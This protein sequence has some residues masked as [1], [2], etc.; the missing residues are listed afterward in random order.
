MT[1]AY[2]QFLL[3]Q[4]ATG[5]Y[6]HAIAA[7][8]PCFWLY[9]HIGAGIDA[10]ADDHPYAAWLREYSDPAFIAATQQALHFVEEAFAEASPTER[11]SAAAAFAHACWHEV[12][13]FDQADCF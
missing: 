13:F 8:L 3:A 1:T 11:A 2:T 12:Y 9:A 4:C 5:S 10:V 7:I 6:L